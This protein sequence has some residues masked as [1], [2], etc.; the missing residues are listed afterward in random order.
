MTYHDILRKHECLWRG[1]VTAQLVKVMGKWMLIFYIIILCV[2]FEWL[3]LFWLHFLDQ[4]LDFL[5]NNNFSIVSHSSDFLFYFAFYYIILSYNI[6]LKYPPLLVYLP[7]PVF[8]VCF[9]NTGLI[10][11][12]FHGF[13][14]LCTLS[15]SLGSC[16][17]GWLCTLSQSLGSF[18]LHCP[19]SPLKQCLITVFIHLHTHLPIFLLCCLLAKLSYCLSLCLLSSIAV[20]R[21]PKVSEEI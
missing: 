2:H 14:W 4:F 13:G 15:Q 1:S 6:N 10:V 18:S 5:S 20:R 7:P 9:L 11:L 3:S 19:P 16:G 21:Q 17:F 8:P 12:G